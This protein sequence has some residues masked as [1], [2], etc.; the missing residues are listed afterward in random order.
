MPWFG[1]IAVAVTVVVLLFLYG[2][3]WVA[4]R[5]DDRD[6]WGGWPG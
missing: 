5:E 1:W 4:R 3:L 2:C 6:T